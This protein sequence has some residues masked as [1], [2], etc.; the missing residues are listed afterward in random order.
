MPSASS[1][2][3]VYQS[4]RQPPKTDLALELELMKRGEMS[5]FFY[6]WTETALVL[7]RGQSIDSINTA[8]CKNERIEI[9]KRI[10]GGTGVLHQHTLNIA[11]ILP[12]N[13]PWAGPI[14]ALYKNFTSAVHHA[15]TEQS[16]DNSFND[17]KKSPLPRSAICFESHTD[18]TLLLNGKK[19]FGSAQRRGRKAILIHGT[20][21]LDLDISQQSRVFNVSPN[22]IDML[23]CAAPKWLNPHQLQTD[24]VNIVA[25]SSRATVITCPYPELEQ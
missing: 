19:V 8:V 13:H 18:D 4:T 10:T 16:V 25:T 15:L 14:N 9:I 2:L 21:L 17:P 5:L 23:M 20:L 24:I 11:L 1:A 7:G 3:H 12:S 22:H 6:H